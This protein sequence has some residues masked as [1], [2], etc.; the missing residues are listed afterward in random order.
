MRH[1]SSYAPTVGD[2]LALNVARASAARLLFALAPWDDRFNFEGRG[3]WY[4]FDVMSDRIVEV[5]P[6]AIYDL[7][8][9]LEDAEALLWRFLHK[10]TGI[11]TVRYR[12]L[13]SGSQP[14]G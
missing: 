8:C 4:W 13:S 10:K 11:E 6:K 7:T 9:A 2:L 14:N 3:C 5:T 12:R 1:V